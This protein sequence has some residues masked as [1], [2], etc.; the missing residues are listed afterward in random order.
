MKTYPL[1]RILMTALTAAVF[2]ACTPQKQE[3]EL[4]D[5][6]TQLEQEAAPLRLAS[7]HAMWEGSITGSE[8]AFDRSARADKALVGLFSNKEVYARLKA[9]QDGGKIKD[10]LLARQLEVL[11]Q[12]Y[13]A[14]QADTL[15]L[16]A[17]IE[18]EVALQQV[19][20]RFRAQYKGQAINDNK[21]EEVLRTSTCNADL[22]AVWKAHKAIG[23]EVAPLILEVVKLRNQKARSLGFDNFHT[24]SLSLSG[25]DPEEVTAL[26][27]EMDALTR[28]GFAALKARM[29]AAFAP[30][31]GVAPRDLMPWHFQNRFFQEAPE[32]YPV[33]LDRYY[34]GQDL[35]T[36]TAAFYRSLGFDIT[37]LLE[38]SD[39]YPKEGKNQHAFCAD[40]DARG[41]V[42]VLCNISDNEQWMNTML[43]EF[44]HGIYALGHDHSSN[45]YFLRDAAHSFTT[46]AVAI[47]FE[48]LSRNPAWMQRN[49]GLSDAEARAIAPDCQRSLRL[50]QLVFSRWGQVVYRFE[51]AM[52]ANPDQDLN[53]LWWDLVEEYQLLRCPEGRRSHPDWAAK[54]HIAIYPCYY[55]NYLLGNL[56][57]SQLQHYI[58]TQITGTDFLTQDYS[59][60]PRAVGTW[61]QE[62]VLRQGMRLPW[63]QMIEQA[64]GEKLTAK[65]YKMQFVD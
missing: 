49:L 24:M 34:K 29:D 28:E 38:N 30:R 55:H 36:L 9:F 25:Q 2:T 4:Q 14:N 12:T 58:S 1:H 60:N 6:I 64:T 20:G 13:L 51:K 23:R 5:L 11:C 8:E 59:Q 41:D 21:V 44:G 65:Y 62:K 47:L 16:N 54:I 22:E 52:Y 26:L 31:Y 42:R 35:E 56:L 33:D 7:A 48:R 10:P 18:K 39:L 3:A 17:I 63:N 53:A 40:M 43:H 19:Y 61:L 46:E 15:L 57:A 27:D 45:P 32:L 37:G 50:S